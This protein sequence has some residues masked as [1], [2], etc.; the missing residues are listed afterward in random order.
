MGK[1][2]EQTSVLLSCFLIAEQ[3]LHT[4][5]RCI[6]CVNC[7]QLK[8]TTIAELL[9]WLQ[10]IEQLKDM[11]MR[12]RYKL[13]VPVTHLQCH[14]SALFHEYEMSEMKHDKLRTGLQTVIGLTYCQQVIIAFCNRV[15]GASHCTWSSDFILKTKIPVI[16]TIWAF[17]C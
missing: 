1:L 9:P 6:K 2:E 14:N 12:I 16:Y 5:W 10:F 7:I 17:E 4:A 11:S 8:C 3:I 15:S 13:A